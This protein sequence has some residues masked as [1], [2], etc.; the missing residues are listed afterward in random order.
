[1]RHDSTDHINSV[2]HSAPVDIRSEYSDSPNH[3]LVARI[4]VDGCTDIGAMD[5]KT[6]EPY[7]FTLSIDDVVV[8]FDTYHYVTNATRK[9]NTLADIFGYPYVDYD[10]YTL[11]VADESTEPEPAA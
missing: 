1:M 10:G 5:S 9:W 4:D 7:V 3:H 8:A 2:R 11:H 6:Y